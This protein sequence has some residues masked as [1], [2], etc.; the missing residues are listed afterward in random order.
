MHVHIKMHKLLAWIELFF[1]KA[2]ASKIIQRKTF[3]LI[4]NMFILIK[5]CVYQ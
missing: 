1:L 2:H 4:K 5:Y 3:K